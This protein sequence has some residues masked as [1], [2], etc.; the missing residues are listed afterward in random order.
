[1]DS[2][3]Y[4]NPPSANIEVITNRSPY[5]SEY[6]NPIDNGDI[7]RLQVACRMSPKEKYVY[8]DI[9]EGT[10]E[11]IS[12]EYSNQ[13][14]TSL[15]CKGHINEASKKAIEENKTWAGTVEAR[16]ILGYFVNPAHYVNR[17]TWLNQ[18]PYVDQ[19][20]SVNF[21]DATSAYAT[22]ADQSFLSTVFQDVEKQGAGNWRIG[23]KCTY[24]A[25]GLLDKTY[26]TWKQLPTVVTDKYRAIEGTARYISST[27]QSSIEDQA[28]RYVVRGG[29]DTSG[30]QF[31]G[32][33][34]D[35]TAIAK[36]DRKT[37]V[38]V[39]SQLK[40]NATCASIAAGALPG[41]IAAAISGTIEMIGTPLAL[42]GDLVE[43]KA[44]STEL[45]GAVISGNM[46]AHRVR[47]NITQNSYRTNIEVGG[48][49][50]DAYDLIANIKTTA[51]TTKCNQVK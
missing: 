35:A 17:L 5:T 13:N 41:K 49:I 10:I 9:F 7:V 39:F 8:V 40:S 51:K 34:T 50:V 21:T 43:V 11:A 28:T 23:T 29:N 6:I 37:D 44:T 3:S 20:G 38:D 47:H 14:N 12:G 22:T 18:A 26:L 42:P 16:T 15:T 48:K 32:S 1:M 19:S 33:A 25:G 30:N 31:S 27:F 2:L 24:T 36:Y 4:S 45:N 46:L